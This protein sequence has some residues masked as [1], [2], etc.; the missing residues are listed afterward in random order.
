MILL[1]SKAV[2]VIAR[3]YY[4][5]QEWKFEMWP[6]ELIAHTGVHPLIVRY[7][8]SK[9]VDGMPAYGVGQVSKGESV[10]LVACVTAAG[11]DFEA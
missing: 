5:K 9:H 4:E 1:V 3:E 10:F 2:I 6:D 7:D 11:D 8:G